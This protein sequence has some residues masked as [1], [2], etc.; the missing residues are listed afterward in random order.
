[1]MVSL[2]Q[3][4]DTFG[5]TE[6]NVHVARH[7]GLLPKELFV[8]GRDGVLIDSSYII[9]RYEF[10][11]RVVNKCHEFYYFLSRYFTDS[12][13]GRI[14]YKIDNSR[15]AQNWTVFVNS[16]MFAYP[17]FPILSFKINELMWAF[18]RYMRWLFACIMKFA[19]LKLSEIDL[20][21][22]HKLKER[23]DKK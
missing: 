8:K 13:M 21:E 19:G 12:E 10:K 3:F 17:E 22:I 20:D 9:R 2:V 5:L 1:M 18:F 11:K 6:N 23:Y 7:K 14:L 15:N 4:C 16:A